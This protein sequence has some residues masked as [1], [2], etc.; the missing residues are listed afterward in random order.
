[1]NLTHLKYAV[2]VSKTGSISK[3]A[4]NLYMSQPNL[5]KAIKDLEANL[6]FLIFRRNSKGITNTTKGS[7]FI[8]Y[9]KSILAQLQIMEN[10]YNPDV[11]G[12]QSFSIHVPCANYISYTV[13]I[14]A[15]K[16]DSEKVIDINYS[17]TNSNS[18]LQSVIDGESFLGIIRYQKNHSDFAESYITEHGM[19]Q[20]K[21]FEFDRIILMSENNVIAENE[22]VLCSDLKNQIEVCHRDENGSLFCENR[23]YNDDGIK[24][25]IVV[26]ERSSQYELLSMLP[27]AYMWSSPCPQAVMKCRHLVQKKCEDK[28][29]TYIDAVIRDKNHKLSEFENMFLD[30][31]RQSIKELRSSYDNSK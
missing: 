8:E 16:L 14:F 7:E 31:L 27:N 10:L 12:K 9:A 1:M 28:T 11:T 21:I 18:V 26:S 29:V 17:E 15:N 13:S 23:D 22:T 3:A 4:D 5:S 20:E 25:R 2:E 6:G 24:K 19:V 30:C